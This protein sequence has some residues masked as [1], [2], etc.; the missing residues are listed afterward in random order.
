LHQ[1][2]TS[3]V[4]FTHS[5]DYRTVVLRGQRFFLTPLQAQAVQL[6]HEYH[7]RGITALSNDFILTEIGSNS[8][9]LR[10]LF[11]RNPEAW[12]A[13]IISRE[14]GMYADIEQLLRE[15]KPFILH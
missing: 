4:I 11:K 3:T 12:K 15:K 9:L 2:H 6:I 7:Q 8:K 1:S 13:L 10:D 14:K 5:P